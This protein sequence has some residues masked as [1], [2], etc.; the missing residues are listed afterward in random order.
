MGG[1]CPGPWDGAAE[2]KLTGQMGLDKPC[3]LLTHFSFV[4][5]NGWTKRPEALASQSS[6]PSTFLP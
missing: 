2:P 3:L 1:I 4:N 5:G 6:Q